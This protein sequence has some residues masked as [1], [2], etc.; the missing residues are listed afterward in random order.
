MLHADPRTVALRD[1]MLPERRP[2]A[3]AHTEI[4]SYDGERARF[5]LFEHV[6]SFWTSL[7][8][9]DPLVVILDDVHRAAVESLDLLD[10][11]VERAAG[12]RIVFV[13][14]LRPPELRGDEARAH[15]IGVLARRPNTVSE[16]LDRLSLADVAELVERLTGVACDHALAAALLDRSGGNPFLRGRAGGHRD[17]AP[18]GALPLRPR[19][20]SRRRVRGHPDGGRIALHARVG[21]AIEAVYGPGDAHVEALAHHFCEAVT[22]GE[23]RRALTYS[24]RAARVAARASAFRTALAHY[25]RAIEVLP[26]AH[27]GERA[28]L[29]LQVGLAESAANAGDFETVRVE[30]RAAMD[31]ARRQ[32]DTLAFARAA[33]CFSLGN[34][35]DMAHPAVIQAIEE[36]LELYTEETRLRV[37]L[38]TRHANA[39]WFA[40]PPAIARSLAARAVEAGRRVGDPDSLALAITR[41]Y[42][43][44]LGLPE[45]VPVRTALT[46]E[47]LGVLPRV[48]DPA[49]RLDGRWH[50][51]GDA[52]ERGDRIA[53]D[54]RIDAMLREAAES[55]HPFAE[56]Y[57]ATFRTARLHLAGR[58][59]E[60]E[61]EARRAATLAA[62]GGAEFSRSVVGIQV[63]VIRLTEGRFDEHVDEFR[64]FVAGRPVAAQIN[65]AL[66][67]AMC[68]RHRDA[69]A[70]FSTLVADDL[71][72]I[73]RDINWPISMV[74]LAELCVALERTDAAGVILSHLMPL[75]QL[76]VVFRATWMHLGAISRRIGLL[77][78]LLGR[79][80]DAERFLRDGVERDA[81]MGAPAFVARGRL[82]LARLL[83]RH[84]GRAARR[85]AAALLEAV[86]A[87]AGRLGLGRLR[88]E[89]ET[90]LGR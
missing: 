63:S 64:R 3:A 89:A 66:G 40:A 23:A 10:F 31:R 82:E 36:A 78:A 77:A 6:A 34:E 54:Q 62:P 18:R 39:Q 2:A 26:L 80:E 15:A 68:G 58:F 59:A 17:G 20:R 33:H 13:V 12:A 70:V 22:V 5:E 61:A 42:R 90:L 7:A 81:R 11:V 44:F 87:D 48:R 60:A 71:A 67:D 24:T 47:L 52:V 75:E 27:G 69:A 19:A 46:E 49:V 73:P 51:I 41:A 37:R 88:A 85:E 30:A 76:H 28:L 9:A 38:L 86:V 43:I 57:A 25:R 16:Q 8:A 84:S 65:L 1:A 29:H 55:P 4:Q 83:R 14:T 21:R 56:W 79:T 45:H 53:F 72:G 50:V 35:A 74:F 32:G